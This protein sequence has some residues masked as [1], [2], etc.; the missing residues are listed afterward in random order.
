MTDCAL[1]KIEKNE[2][3]PLHTRFRNRILELL[4]EGSLKVGDRLPSRNQ[5]QKVVGISST[6]YHKAV[7]ELIQEGILTAHHGKGVYVKSICGRSVPERVI[8][9]LIAEPEILEHIAFTEVINGI[10]DILVPRKYSLKFTFF[11]PS[12][13]DNIRE[14]LAASQCD[15]LIVPF[16][17]GRQAEQ[18]TVLKDW[19]IPIVFLGRSLPEIS[20]LSVETDSSQAFAA[21]PD[22]FDKKKMR[23]AYIGQPLKEFYRRHS[24][25][26]REGFRKH[27]CELQE[28]HHYICH[29]SQEGGSLMMEK[30]ISENA[31]YDFIVAEDD[32]VACGIL[33]VLAKYKKTPPPLVTVGGFLK[34]LYPLN[35]HPAIDLNYRKIG[36]SSAELVLSA[37]KG[38]LQNERIIVESEL[39]R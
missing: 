31:Q 1:L 20:T 18:F 4:A 10:L 26:I 36:R 5:I 28:L 32:Y 39:Y 33:S 14:K 27:G 16:F 15:G 8:T 11:S 34:H 23:I 29:F 19:N 17:A 6:P 9:L 22:L 21:I 24:R 12:K 3:I 25:W 13:Q 37:L 7:N 35:S 38:T 2:S 30:L